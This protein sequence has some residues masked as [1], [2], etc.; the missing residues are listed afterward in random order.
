MEAETRIKKDWRADPP[1]SGGE[2][3]GVLEVFQTITGEL[4][5]AFFKHS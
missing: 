4:F 5:K 3:E 1:G 2:N